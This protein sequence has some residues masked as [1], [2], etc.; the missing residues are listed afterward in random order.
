MYIYIYTRIYTYVYPYI[1]VYTYHM[2]TDIKFT[3]VSSY[4]QELTDEMMF[5]ISTRI[6]GGP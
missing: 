1:H 5:S 2:S 3:L 6:R 4:D